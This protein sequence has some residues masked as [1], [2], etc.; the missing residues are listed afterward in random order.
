MKSAAQATT[1]IAS[2]AS[3]EIAGRPFQFPFSASSTAALASNSATLACIPR[4]STSGNRSA[5]QS[6]SPVE[7]SRAIAADMRSAPAAITSGCSFSAIAAAAKAFSGCTGT[8]T[9]KKRA[10]PM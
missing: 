5:N 6:A 10:V 9:L 8:G 4:T 3:S 2:P 1:A 7:A